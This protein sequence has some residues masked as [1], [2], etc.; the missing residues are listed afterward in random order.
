MQGFNTNV[1]F[2]QQIA[3]SA[4]L[5]CTGT[6]TAHWWHKKRIWPRLLAPFKASEPISWV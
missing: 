2:P 4:Y 5:H 1:I 6:R 3:S